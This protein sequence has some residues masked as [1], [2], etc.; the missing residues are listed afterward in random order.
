MAQISS[1]K[2]IENAY[3]LAKEVHNRSRDRAKIMIMY[4]DLKKHMSDEFREEVFEDICKTELENP[5]ERYDRSFKD[6][7]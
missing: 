4:Q 6:E 5:H 1:K 3:N 7:G 2:L